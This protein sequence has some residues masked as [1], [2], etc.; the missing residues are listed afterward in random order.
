MPPGVQ[1][2]PP[3]QEGGNPSSSA[4]SL[5]QILTPLLVV[6]R[7]TEWGMGPRQ[8]PGCTRLVSTTFRKKK[9]KSSGVGTVQPGFCDQPFL[10]TVRWAA[11]AECQTTNHPRECLSG[12]AP[13]KAPATHVSPPLG[14][15]GQKHLSARHSSTK[16]TRRHSKKNSHNHTPCGTSCLWGQSRSANPP[17]SMDEAN[18]TDMRS[19][20]GRV[21]F[22]K[23]VASQNV[24]MCTFNVRSAA[25]SLLR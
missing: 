18:G 2:P 9:A 11:A 22:Q 1:T 24:S 10:P 4:T 5:N 25:P 15:H 13:P 17:P 12:Q 21:L 7:G 16:S 19:T 14:A 6:E 8:L 3:I 20:W 23:C